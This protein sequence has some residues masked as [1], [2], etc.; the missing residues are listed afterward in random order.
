[1]KSGECFGG[2]ESLSTS[3]EIEDTK[4]VERSTLKQCGS[5]P[6]F[7]SD[8]SSSSSETATVSS[9]AYLQ[10]NQV[11]SLGIGELSTLDNNDEILRL[12]HEQESLVRA[13]HVH[14]SRMRSFDSDTSSVSSSKTDSS[15][16]TF[17]TNRTSDSPCNS[18]EYN[19]IKDDFGPTEMNFL[20]RKIVSCPVRPFPN[21]IPEIPEGTT[22][23]RQRH[24]VQN[25]YANV[26][27]LTKFN[28]PQ[29]LGTERNW[30][31]C[32]ET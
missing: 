16:R 6:R 21:E 19:R 5:F 20:S 30:L 12:E 28:P 26:R 8:S 4:D 1:M 32:M 22:R 29:P 24:E 27:H 14:G 2:S 17:E 11:Q 18:G 9:E 31:L 13:K 3:A 15:R 25:K 7:T 10:L 23:S